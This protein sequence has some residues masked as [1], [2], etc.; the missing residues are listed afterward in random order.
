[1]LSRENLFFIFE[2]L[3]QKGG[4][5]EG[6]GFGVAGLGR[7]QGLGEGDGCG[8]RNFNVYLTCVFVMFLELLKAVLCQIAR[9]CPSQGGGGGGCGFEGIKVFLALGF[10]RG[11][12]V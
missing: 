9:T 11:L 4:S 2:E 7:V 5:R 12:R 10:R 8:L 1:M 3:K 6:L